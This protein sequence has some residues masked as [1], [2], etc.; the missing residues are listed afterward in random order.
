MFRLNLASGT[1]WL[2]LAGGVEVEVRPFGTEVTTRV[3]DEMPDDIRDAI[4]AG[5]AGR[6]VGLIKAFA[7]AAIIAWKGVGMA[8]S[9]T[10]VAPWPEGIDAL[11]EAYPFGEAFERGYVVPALLLVA[12][13]NASAPSP[14]GTS[15]AAQPIV[16]PAPDVATS[17]PIV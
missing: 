1:Y 12:E 14:N 16:P 13:K 5:G 2:R 3:R 7:R 8:D 17:A 4:I 15:A 10:E 9:E 11:M 6:S